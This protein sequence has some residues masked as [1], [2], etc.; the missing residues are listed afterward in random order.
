VV[1]QRSVDTIYDAFLDRVAEGRNLPRAQV[2]DLAQGR[3]WSG[4]AALDL[5]LVDQLGGLGPAITTAAE[6]AELGDDW[7]LQDY[8]EP[9]EW[10]R[11]LRI[12][13]STEATVATAQ[14]P[15]TAQV[16]QFVDETQ[17]IRSLNDP[18]GAYALMPYR[19]VVK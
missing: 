6:L 17:L 11:F 9:N 4:K 8:P 7:R 3:V 18:R 16:L 10:Q 15:L 13:L 14:A 19:F 1:L 2:A 12:F 5:G